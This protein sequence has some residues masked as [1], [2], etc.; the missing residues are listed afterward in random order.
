MSRAAGM[1]SIP[2]KDDLSEILCRPISLLVVA[3][4]LQ[5]GGEAIAVGIGDLGDHL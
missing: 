4:S 3:D 2:F 1:P 5:K